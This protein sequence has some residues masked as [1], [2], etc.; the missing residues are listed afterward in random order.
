MV[1]CKTV[2]RR[3]H[4]EPHTRVKGDDED[5]PGEESSIILAPPT[6]DEDDNG[7]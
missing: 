2:L 4:K 7:D 6:F 1:P 3:M 5:I